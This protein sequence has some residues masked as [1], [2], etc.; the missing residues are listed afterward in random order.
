MSTKSGG[1]TDVWLPDGTKREEV[2]AYYE[3]VASV[4]LPHL[5]GRPLVLR[6]TPRG[7]RPAA[8]YT[9][10][11]PADLPDW[12]PAVALTSPD[13]GRSIDYALVEEPRDLLW[14][15]S[16]GAFELHA[17]HSRV[18][19]P[20]LPDHAFFDLDP[21]PGSSYADACEAALRLRELLQRLGLASCVRS[22]GLSGLHVHVPLVRRYPFGQ[23]REWVRRVS[24]RLNSEAPALTT[25]TWSDAARRGVFLDH[26][27]NAANKNGVAALSL[28]LAP[29]ARIAMPLDW[30]EVEQ[31]TPPERF[32]LREATG[33]LDHARRLLQPLLDGRQDLTPALEALAMDAKPATEASHLAGPDWRRSARRRRV[34]ALI[35]GWGPGEGQE[36][37]HLSVVLVGLRYLDELAYVGRVP[38]PE[39][40][41][42]ALHVLLAEN[43]AADCPFAV[44]P[45]VRGA[46]WVAPRLVC[47]IECAGLMPG[48]DLRASRFLGL[49]PGADPA[50]CCGLDELGLA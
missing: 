21:S 23:V 36:S 14:L 49:E 16:R 47:T 42:H 13:S 18:D 6:L 24:V 19:A 30:V 27:M 5:R 33:R 35:G 4:M 44:A 22:T 11:A 17:W 43:A 10:Q 20:G 38:V 29:Q 50:R 12:A 1:A 45:G 34:S 41:K 8:A 39:E 37:G 26:R 9:R 28:R 31:R 48:P 46:R 7:Y 2:L 40:Q 15:V 3:R 25:M 32:T